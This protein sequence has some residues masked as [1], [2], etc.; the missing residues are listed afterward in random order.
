MLSVLSWFIALNRIYQRG[1]GQ[2]P[3]SR[4]EVPVWPTI[5]RNI[6]LG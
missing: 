3:V 4:G 5:G 2:G 1:L 6:I